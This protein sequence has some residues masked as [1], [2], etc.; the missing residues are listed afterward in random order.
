[1]KLSRN[2]LIVM[3]SK[4]HV[5]LRMGTSHCTLAPCLVWCSWVFCRWRYNLFNLSRDLTWL[6]HWGLKRVYWWE[7]LVVCH[8]PDK[9]C[10]HKHCDS[11]DMFLVCHVAS[12]K[13][14]IWIYGWKFPTM[15]HHLAV[16]GG[17]WT[18]ANA[19]I[20][21]LIGHVTSQNHV[22]EGS[23]NF[24]IRSYHRLIA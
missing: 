3:W 16:F 6:P 2:F 11:G 13:H 18:Y 10:D 24:I 15:S 5:A 1:M 22:I 12:R 17:H 21:Y 19:N 8:H 4:G 23:S 7:H 20:K 14:A 9:S